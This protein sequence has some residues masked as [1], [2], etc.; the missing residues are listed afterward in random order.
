LVIANN[1]PARF[2]RFAT[3]IRIKR[4]AR[5]NTVLVKKPRDLLEYGVVHEFRISSNRRTANGFSACS[6]STSRP[7]AKPERNSTTCRKADE[8]W[9]GPGWKAP[10][11]S[12]IVANHRGVRDS[13]VLILSGSMLRSVRFRR[14]VLRW[15]RAAV[16]LR[17]A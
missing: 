7:G 15:L 5:L 17:M 3:V 8:M 4:E 12:W 16:A 11:S 13:T 1:L 9:T 6:T 2:V 10:R 14:R